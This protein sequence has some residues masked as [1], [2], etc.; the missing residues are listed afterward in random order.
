[1]LWAETRSKK[2][3]PNLHVFAFEILAA[4][5]LSAKAILSKVCI[6]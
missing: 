2:F 3:L 5:I 4:Y 1:M 6:S